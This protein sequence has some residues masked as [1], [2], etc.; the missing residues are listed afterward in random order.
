MWFV[1][2]GALAIAGTGV[3]A[4]DVTPDD[5]SGILALTEEVVTLPVPDAIR[6]HGG[7]LHISPCSG[8]VVVEETLEHTVSTD[9]DIPLEAGIE[10]VRLRAK[11]GSAQVEV[12]F[13]HG[14]V[15]VPQPSLELSGDWVSAAAVKDLS[16][17]YRA[18]VV[19]E[20]HGS[21]SLLQATPLEVHVIPSHHDD[22]LGE[23]RVHVTD[24]S[25]GTVVL[26]VRSGMASNTYEMLALPEGPGWIFII[27]CL[28]AL[29]FVGGCAFNMFCRGLTGVNAIPLFPKRRQQQPAAGFQLDERAQHYYADYGY[30]PM[31]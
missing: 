10:D 17:H 11:E 5:S 21:C 14:D 8:E 18:V 27:A 3:R 2:F 20:I 15:Q 30:N 16:A 19:S 24:E 1:L 28:T 25:L 9:T 6:Q 23:V 13:D 7:K 31:S 22:E 29:Y 12:R 4:D 26:T